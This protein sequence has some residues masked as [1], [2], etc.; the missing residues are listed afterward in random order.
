MSFGGS[1]SPT[2]TSSAE[3]YAPSVPALNQIITESA[4]IYGQGPSGYVPPSQLTLQGLTAQEALATQANQQ[5]AATMQGQYSNPFLSP[6]I[7]QAAK[8]VYSGVA[9]QFTGAGRT[10]S[11]PLGQAQ[12]TQGVAEKA[13]PYAF[14]AYENERARQLNTASGMP[15][16]TSVG[17][18]LED[19][20]RQQQ[21][22]EYQN[23]LNYVNI[24]N[25]IARGGSTTQTVGPAPNRLGQFAGGALAGASIGSKLPEIGGISGTV[26][27]GILGG[28]GGL[29]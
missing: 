17:Q 3:P 28:L 15:S 9:G 5:L 8:D 23:L 4:R 29:L 12:V 16:L 24:I 26:Y 1:S 19:Y 7:A 2:T 21:Q 10:V 22:A 14:Q 27:G 20:Q 6:I 13:L 25:P 11:S 18:T